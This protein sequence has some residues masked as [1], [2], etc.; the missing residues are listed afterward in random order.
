VKNEELVDYAVW[1]YTSLGLSRGNFWRAH[2]SRKARLWGR[3]A[4]G[5][6]VKG[7]ADFVLGFDQAADTRKSYWLSRSRS[8]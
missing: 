3:F 5:N 1:L 6:K 2:P 4:V 7:D 8:G